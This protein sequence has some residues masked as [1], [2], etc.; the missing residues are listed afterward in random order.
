MIC[1]QYIVN[2]IP[3]GKLIDRG[4]K[5]FFNNLSYFSVAPLETERRLCFI[6]GC[7]HSGT[8]LLSAKLSKHPAVFA[9]GRESNNFSPLRNRYFSREIAREWCYTAEQFEK[10]HVIEKT[11]KHVQT[12]DRILMV[13]PH[14]N[15]VLMVRNPLDTCASLFLRFKNLDMGLKRRIQDNKAVIT[16]KKRFPYS[17]KIVLYEELTENPLYEMPEICQF[18]DLEWNADILGEG[19]TVYSLIEQ[20]SENMISR[21]EQVRLRIVPNSGKWKDRLT[22]QQIDLIKHKTEALADSL[23]YDEEFYLKFS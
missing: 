18:L 19:D 2:P 5:A 23:G 3:F 20:R 9:V 15:I 12:L 17:I 16:F 21:K 8:T 22:E 7:G 10:S 11:P 6:A 13:L 14:A 4:F 1:L